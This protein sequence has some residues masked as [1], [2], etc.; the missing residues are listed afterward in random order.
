M[1]TEKFQ[2]EMSDS[3]GSFA[4]PVTLIV[5]CAAR[6]FVKPLTTMTAITIKATAIIAAAQIT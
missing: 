4:L 1:L 5:S 3:T 6:T 2:T